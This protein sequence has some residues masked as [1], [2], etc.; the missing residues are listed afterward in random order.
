MP[1]VLSCAQRHYRIDVTAFTV[2]R[3]T[4]G[5]ASP[6]ASGAKPRLASLC[7]GSSSDEDE[8]GIASLHRGCFQACCLLRPLMNGP[9]LRPTSNHHLVFRRPPPLTLM[10][11]SPSPASVGM[12]ALHGSAPTMRSRL[13][14][15]TTV[16]GT[17]PGAPTSHA[18]LAG[19]PLSFLTCSTTASRLPSSWIAL[20]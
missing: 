7:W 3:K 15:R 17:T 2:E 8:V 11:R 1:E 9:Q 16:T 6:G 12:T 18:P 13:V 5:R 4:G 19:A 10:G 20:P 14:A